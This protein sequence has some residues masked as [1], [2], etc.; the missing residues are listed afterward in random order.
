MSK[1]DDEAALLARQVAKAAS[2]LLREPKDHTVYR[3][4]VEAVEQWDT[5]CSPALTS[6]TDQDELL[7]ALA[8]QSPPQPLGDLLPDLDSHLRRAHRNAL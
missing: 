7:D 2:A 5:Y 1:M 6:S 3:R 8:D 4:F